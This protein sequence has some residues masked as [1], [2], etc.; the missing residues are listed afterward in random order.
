MQFV[1]VL[2]DRDAL[3]CFPFKADFPCGKSD[4][5]GGTASESFGAQGVSNSCW[6]PFFW[7]T[8]SFLAHPVVLASTNSFVSAFN[9]YWTL[10]QQTLPMSSPVVWTVLIVAW[11]QFPPC[12]WHLRSWTWKQKQRSNSISRSRHKHF[13]DQALGP[14]QNYGSICRPP[15]PKPGS[16]HGFSC[17]ENHHTHLIYESV[18][19]IRLRGR[20]G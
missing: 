15:W 11:P 10:R 5:W 1:H 13:D 14:H 18:R 17:K 4:C 9:R 2:S 3:V 8:I 12:N 7:S 20:R 19:C 16:T 6:Q